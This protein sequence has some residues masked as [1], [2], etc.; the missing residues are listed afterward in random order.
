MLLRLVCF[1]TPLTLFLR[2]LRYERIYRPFTVRTVSRVQRHFQHLRSLDEL[3][4]E[5]GKT[6]GVMLTDSMETLSS[7]SSWNTRAKLGKVALTFM[8]ERNI[9]LNQ[10]H[11]SCRWFAPMV[12]QILDD[13][14]SSPSAVSG[15]LSDLSEDNGRMLGK[16]R[17]RRPPKR[18]PATK[19]SPPRERR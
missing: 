12:V 1:P 9:A 10:V 3:D 5:D 7:A 15:S 16:V 4:Y 6:I 19:K 17:A 2:S 14:R 8:F 11:S 13:S 18:S